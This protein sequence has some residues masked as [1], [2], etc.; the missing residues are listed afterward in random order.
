M[1]RSFRQSEPSG[2]RDQR[3]ESATAKALPSIS[4]PRTNERQGRC[5]K[6][7]RWRT[8]KVNAWRFA[9]P[10]GTSPSAC[11]RSSSNQTMRRSRPSRSYSSENFTTSRI[12]AFRKSDTSS[13]RQS[14]GLESYRGST[15]N[16]RSDTAR[17]HSTACMVPAGSHKALGGRHGTNG[18][19][20]GLNCNRPTVSSRSA[21][22]T[23]RRTTGPPRRMHGALQQPQNHSGGQSH[24]DTTLV[25]AQI[26]RISCVALVP[27]PATTRRR[28]RSRRIAQA[29]H[30]PIR[31]D[32]RRV[33]LRGRARWK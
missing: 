22:M 28:L 29:S 9:M 12:N 8:G 31:A 26:C 5:G 10:G 23:R 2:C 16:V 1:Y 7:V 17:R 13:T 25:Q 32:S 6:L 27:G 4:L 21:L 11:A 24:A 20:Q 14:R 18:R 30:A 3:G 15:Y 33:D 19:Q